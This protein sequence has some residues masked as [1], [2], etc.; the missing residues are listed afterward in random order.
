MCVL[1]TDKEKYK[2]IRDF[3]RVLILNAPSPFTAKQIFSV[4]KEYNSYSRDIII[5]VLSEICDSG[6]ITYREGKFYNKRTLNHCVN[7]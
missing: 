4:T 3:I 2:S 5:D 7:I 6:L 1:V